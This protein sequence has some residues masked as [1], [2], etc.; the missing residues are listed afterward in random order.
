[1]LGTRTKQIFSYGRRNQRVVN[2]YEE[3]D[4][5]DP[6][7]PQG[8]V[9]VPRAPVAARTRKREDC[10]TLSES[11]APPARTVRIRSKKKQSSP[12][13]DSQTFA[14]KQ[15]RG[16][17][18]IESDTIVTT[19]T[20]PSPERAFIDHPLPSRRPLSAYPVNIP[21]SSTRI[22]K[23]KVRKKGKANEG[24]PFS[25]KTS[26][27]FVD[28]EILI[29]DGDGRRI[30]QERRVSRTDII[31][32]PINAD[33]TVENA[34]TRSADGYREN[35]EDTFDS[36]DD[37]QPRPA[38]RVVRRAKAITI[39]SDESDASDT[40]PLETS[41]YEFNDCPVQSDSSDSPVPMN[42]PSPID[43]TTPPPEST[44][45]NKPL[46]SALSFPLESGLSDMLIP[47]AI[48]PPPRAS[49]HHPLRH[50]F[51]SL[52][53]TPPAIPRTRLRPRFPSPRPRP[54]QLTPMRNGAGAR[55]L[56]LFERP[57]LS[58]PSTLTDSDLSLECSV[59]LDLDIGT[60]PSG[61]PQ[62]DGKLAN[63]GLCFEPPP[64]YLMP[65]LT[66]CDQEESGPHEFSAFIEMFPVDPIVWDARDKWMVNDARFRKIGEAS[67]SEVFGIGDVVLKIIPLRDET[68]NGRAKGPT[69]TQ[70]WS[71]S[72]SK[73]AV[74]YGNAPQ[75]REE[76]D[77][78]PPSDAKDVLKEMIVTRAMGDICDG[79]VKLLR[80]YVVRGRYPERLLKLW[81]DFFERKGSENVRPGAF[82]P[83][84]FTWLQ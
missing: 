35:G 56:R 5:K 20:A 8:A 10:A 32:N 77:G 65:L 68:P 1:M 14:E 53:V 51:R 82:N 76:R 67:Y 26:S 50:H 36:D 43:S 31:M 16:Q 44:P 75:E 58:S 57:P 83:T 18:T 7:S 11:E 41:P 39:I 81:D 66:E 54:R 45:A 48:S 80:T 25:L 74:A 79:F 33:N 37:V 15:T 34:R 84:M 73:S 78:P 69:P 9:M 62:L 28:V 13:Q 2:V 30:S 47:L 55:S 59:D 42:P 21:G 71:K 27:P 22:K 6:F 49:H 61:L 52:M 3:R 19:S 24:T 46:Q 38:R 17:A 70:A 72:K 29:L 60:A 4:K 23:G 40:A 63:A 12:L 64:E